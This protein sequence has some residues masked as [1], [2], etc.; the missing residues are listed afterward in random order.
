M[1]AGDHI[2]VRRAGGF[3]HGID[4]GDRTVIAFE[5][6]S[7][8]RRVLL[9]RFSAGA[10]PE[11]VTHTERVY[12]PKQVVARAFSR[13]SEGAYAT[14]FPDS[15]AFAVWCKAGRPAGAA[16]PPLVFPAAP[17]GAAPAALAKAAKPAARNAAPA[18]VAAQ[19]KAKAGIKAKAR[20]PVKAKAAPTK[21]AA[22]APAGKAAARKAH[23]SKAGRTKAEAKVKPV[24]KAAAAR[25]RSQPARR[26]PRKR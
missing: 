17:A 5:A 6:G 11:V 2:R 18:K 9:A 24:P 8:P 22:K 26:P 14:M 12:A 15:E 19:V 21:P 7:G 10:R 4:V 3:L 13:F 20:A 25:R 23:P 16:L 1:K